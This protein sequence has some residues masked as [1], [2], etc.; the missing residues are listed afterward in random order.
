[1]TRFTQI[2]AVASP[3]ARKANALDV[4]M[5]SIE[6]E[7]AKQSDDTS[8]KAAANAAIAHRLAIDGKV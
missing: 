4:L 2:I 6:A 7:A 8:K 1:M 3:V 5:E